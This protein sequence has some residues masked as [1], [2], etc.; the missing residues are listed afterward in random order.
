MYKINWKYKPFV[1]MIDTIGNVLFFWTKFKKFPKKINKIL[2]IRLD[3][4]GD[5]ILTTPIFRTLKNNFPNAKVHV[6][7]RSI[8]KPIID[9]NSNINK[10]IEYNASWFSRGEKKDS[11]F[12]IAKKLKM[13]KYDLILELKGDPRNV[14]LSFLAGGYRVG[15][16]IRGFGFLLNKTIKWKGLKHITE[17][18][19]DALRAIGCQKILP[20]LELFV[21]KNS[22]RSVKKFQNNICIHSGVG[23][24]ERQ[25]PLE[26]F[27]ELIN[28]LNQKVIL[29][30][31]DKSRI[32]SIMKNVKNKNNV[33]VLDNLNLK[34]LIALIKN[35]KLFIGLESVGI[36]I[37]SAVGTP[38]IDIHSGV[39]YKEEWGPYQGKFIVLQKF[40]GLYANR[41]EAKLAM[42]KIKPWDVMEAI[43]KL[44]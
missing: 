2:V 20:K 9:N 3:H 23:A 39:T 6:L 14:L 21:D 33:V 26:Y 11:F 40:V 18:Y 28:L 4:I 42:E 34:Q 16:N 24:A 29:V 38:L 41:K 19:L 32:K 35:S 37:A 36:H 12:T 44:K 15:Y 31:T 30:D 5:M 1:F 43:N 17:R 27:S 22:E 25:W 13:E 8:A 10:I 7:S